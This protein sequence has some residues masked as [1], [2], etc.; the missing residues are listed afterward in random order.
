MSE[1]QPP[2]YRNVV[3]SYGVHYKWAQN[4]P[5]VIVQQLRAAN[6]L[7][8]EL[9]AGWREHD[10][11]TVP[12]IWAQDP[13]VDAAMKAEKIALAD[14]RAAKDALKAENS[15]QGTKRPTGTV[16][17]QL[18]ADIAAAHDRLRAASAAL[19][20][21]QKRAFPALKDQFS[22]AAK[23]LNVAQGTPLYQKYCAQGVLH[24]ATANDVM[25]N[26]Y[27]TAKTRVKKDRA[28]GQRPTLRF[29]RFDGTG[30]LKITLQPKDKVGPAT[31]ETLADLDSAY[32]NLLSLPGWM[33]PEQFAAMSRAD[34]R[35]HG[36]VIARMQ[37]GGRGTQGGK[38]IVEIPVQVHRMLP[39][40]AEIREARL[41]VNQV[42]SKKR[43]SLNITARVPITEPRT[44]PGLPVVAVHLGW[45]NEEEGTRRV[46]TWQSD[47]PIMVPPS[48]EGI[49]I[50]DRTRT[51]GKILVPGAWHDQDDRLDLLQGARQDGLNAAAQ[52]L[53]A[54]LD[55]HGPT[56]PPAVLIGHPMFVDE[57]TGQALDLTASLVRSWIRPKKT[58]DVP[59]SAT[60][61]LA[62]LARAWNDDPPALPD[63]LETVAMLERWRSQDKKLWDRIGF[64][65]RKLVKRRDDA[66][67]CIAKMF[68]DQASA[69]LVDS[70]SIAELKKRRDDVKS[71]A[72]PNELLSTTGQRR[73]LSAPGSLRETLVAAAV[74]DG[75]EVRE[76]ESKGITAVHL[77][78]TAH[79]DVDLWETHQIECV[80]C[81]EVYDVD[82]NA[83]A[84][85]LDAVA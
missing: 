23:A 3:Y 22:A 69:L 78:C 75:V 84:T 7:W 9:V 66:Y 71:T 16:V 35:R 29:H 26:G 85:M 34:Q 38:E 21:E 30:R 4:L 37:V 80:E 57:K 2:A 82:W 24:H 64:G 36:R 65:S 15:R 28:Q 13:A 20:A 55:Q 8:N 47:G 56:Q 44:G 62:V 5:E 12:G 58:G 17:H 18:R 60:R 70:M 19:K 27:A 49:V 72:L 45:R 73:D 83:T 48:L 81:G 14:Y 52:E 41:V 74:R 11:V 43:A 53:I 61:R 25:R 39:A 79:N 32:A 51:A 1:K 50:A 10:E 77:G 54:W 68:A 46:A 63:G 6:A 59:T 42:G 33:P 31:P 67:S 76:I 40:G